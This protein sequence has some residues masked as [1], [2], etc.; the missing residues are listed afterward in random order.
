MNTQKLPSANIQ[1]THTLF[2]TFFSLYGTL[3]L[4]FH[5]LNSTRISA[6][7]LQLKYSQWPALCQNLATTWLLQ[8]GVITR[9]FFPKTQRSLYFICLCLGSGSCN[10]LPYMFCPLFG[11]SQWLSKH[12]LHSSI[13]VNIRSPRDSLSVGIGLS[14]REPLL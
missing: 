8:A 13:L 11:C 2:T 7:P 14:L 1:S 4:E 6:F 3:S 10:P 5:Q 12:D 9:R